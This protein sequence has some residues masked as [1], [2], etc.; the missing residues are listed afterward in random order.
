MMEIKLNNFK[1][2]FKR[3]KNI[4]IKFIKFL[5]F[6]LFPKLNSKNWSKLTK[7]EIKAQYQ[8]DPNSI[9]PFDDLIYESL[10]DLEFTNLIEFGCHKGQRLVSLSKKYPNKLF[11]G[12]EI[13]H[14]AV[15]LGTEL[16]KD[17]NIN[18]VQLCQYD[19]TKIINCEKSVD[20]ILSCATLIYISPLAI[21]KTIKN[22]IRFKPSYVVLIEVSTRLGDSTIIRIIRKFKSF[23]NWDHNFKK[24]FHSLG[25]V[26]VSSK[27]VESQV[28]SPGGTEGQ[29]LIFQ[30]DP[31][32]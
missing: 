27:I 11:F 30:L 2:I 14:S 22:M 23:P 24:I 17:K 29:L 31:L 21:K 19:I 7:N 26:L 3:I 12:I 8:S 4:I 20:I 5:L 13:N 18:N 32:R 15:E 10:K 1:K 9:D 16:L 28:W 25:Y 6:L